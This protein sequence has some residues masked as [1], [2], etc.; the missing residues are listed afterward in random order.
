[1]AGTDR[2]GGAPAPGGAGGA[3][4]RGEL[5][6][7][8]LHTVTTKPWPL[9]TAIDAYARAGFGGISIWREALEGREPTAV[10]RRLREAG[11]QGVSLVRGGFF[12]A[13]EAA[14]RREALEENRR[15]IA[16]AAELELPLVVL[17]VGADPAQSLEESRR[18]I[19]EALEYL[20]PV[21]R[22]AGL[23]LAIEPLHPMYADTR[24]AVNSLGSALDLALG[25][26]ATRQDRETRRWPVICTALDVYHLW[27]DPELSAQ[28][29]R[30]GRSG[31]IGAF[32]VCDWKVPT[33]DLLL[34]RGLMGE[35]CIDIPG[36]RR[37]LET[38]GFVGLREV[39]IFSR[40]YWSIDQGEWLEMIAD[41]CLRAV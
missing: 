35:G 17:V 41:A 3:A 28:I 27:W 16:E 2:A 19:A 10:R 26:D 9:E 14:R 11:L 34:D 15:V 4:P 29:R 24:S 39:E 8:A 37:E 18:Q 36:I 5:A 6:R 38:A 31:M 13:A 22:E 30:A 21:A 1:M 25:L 20:A 23:R 33:E 32:H 40:H 12:A 7:F